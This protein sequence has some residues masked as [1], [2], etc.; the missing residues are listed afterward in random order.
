VLT[1]G[2]NYRFDWWLQS[3]VSIIIGYHARRNITPFSKNTWLTKKANE[4]LI[5]ECSQHT[6]QACI[7]TCIILREKLNL[8]LLSSI[9]TMF[10][11]IQGENKQKQEH[12]K[13]ERK[14]SENK[15][16]QNT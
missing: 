14:R 6:L 9:A 4:V 15:I 12:K 13:K 1:L 7:K 16:R 2:S 8:L 11:E 3:R 5:L 10:V